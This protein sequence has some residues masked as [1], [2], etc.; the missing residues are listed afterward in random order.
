MLRLELTRSGTTCSQMTRYLRHQ[1]GR[2]T[3]DA[4]PHIK[5][6][7]DLYRALL[8]QASDHRSMLQAGRWQSVSRPEHSI[9][10]G[11]LVRFTV[12]R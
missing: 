9:T 8:G 10:E 6:A 3:F 1:P 2:C 12:L 4:L 5:S 7:S 11:D